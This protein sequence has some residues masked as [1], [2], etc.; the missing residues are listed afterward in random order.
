MHPADALTLTGYRHSIY[1]RIARMALV[2]K[3]AAF[4]EIEVNPFAPPLPRGYPHPFGRVPVLTHGSFTLYET[5]AIARYIDLAL[6]DPPLVPGDPKAAARMQQVIAIADAYAFHPLVLQ[7]YAHRVFRPLEGLPPDEAEV[8]K[9][10]ARAPAILA[11]LEAI[12]AEGLTLD[13][14]SPSLADCHLAPMVVAFTAADKGAA[15]LPGYPALS[16]WWEN[17]RCLPAFRASGR[18][19]LASDPLP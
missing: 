9:G 10:L 5:S 17:I 16:H 12:A 18:D 3:G 8:A 4:T 7:V 2:A 14:A 1:S 11:A 19:H 15:L 13:P 6:P